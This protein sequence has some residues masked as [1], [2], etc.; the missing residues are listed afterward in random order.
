ME[1]AAYPF[2]N[3]T[4]SI[5]DVL[6]DPETERALAGVSPGVQGCDRHRQVLGQLLG[7]KKAIGNIHD[8]IVRYHP[9]TRVLSGF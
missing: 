7:R 1:L 4:P 6:P 3:V 9:V 2:I 8:R 5:T